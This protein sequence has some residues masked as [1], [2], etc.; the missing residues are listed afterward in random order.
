MKERTHLKQY[1]LK[2]YLNA[3]HFII[4]NGKK[5]DVHPHTWEFLLWISFTQDTF[6]EFSTFEKGISQFLQKY[7]NQTMNDFDPFNDVIPTIENIT[8]Y[9]GEMF[10]QIITSVGGQ[11]ERIEASETPTRT[12]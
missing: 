4:I 11:L 2:F 7:Q 8:D 12:F 3:R 5:G 6:T 10:A 1:K 9:F